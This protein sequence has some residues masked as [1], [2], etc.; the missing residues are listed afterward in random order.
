MAAGGG[1]DIGGEGGPSPNISDFI[2]VR[3]SPISGLS[4][5]YSV[6]QNPSFGGFDP[7]GGIISLGG[8]FNPGA[9]MNFN[10]LLQPKKPEKPEPPP[11]TPEPPPET[12]E[13]DER[14]WRE[15]KAAGEYPVLDWFRDKAGKIGELVQKY[16]WDVVKNALLF[17]P[18][19]R[20]FVLAWEMKEAFQEGGGGGLGEFFGKM[21]MQKLFGKNLDVAGGIYGVA[22]GNMTLGE[23]LGKI[24]LGRG[25]K[26]GIRE[27]VGV[28]HGQWGMNGVRVLLPM[29]KTGLQ[30]RGQG[31][32]GP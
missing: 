32:G 4:G 11:E 22:S 29:L 21:G 14:S 15:K 20:P 5:A 26:A 9:S 2:E 17:N 10:N 7:G 16:G 19:T 24:V 3:A 30:A 13:K 28:V 6:Y 1:G 25:M 31:P 27:L 12:K 8:G 18:Q 23:G